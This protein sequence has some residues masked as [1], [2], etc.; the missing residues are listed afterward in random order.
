MLP[1]FSSFFNLKLLRGKQRGT[2]ATAPIAVRLQPLESE[3]TKKDESWLQ[4]PES[5]TRT[6]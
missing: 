2:A 4:T 5:K 1:S 6:L 3:L